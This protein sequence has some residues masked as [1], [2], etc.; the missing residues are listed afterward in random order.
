M[1]LFLGENNPSTLLEHFAPLRGAKSFQ[2]RSQGRLTGESL[3]RQIV[4]ADLGQAGLQG[5]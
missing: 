2:T 1:L 3:S 4:R 5:G